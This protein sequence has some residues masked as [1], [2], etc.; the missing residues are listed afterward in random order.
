MS[1]IPEGANRSRANL[2]TENDPANHGK[3]PLYDHDDPTA[4]RYQ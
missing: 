3:L 2:T 1:S 4:T